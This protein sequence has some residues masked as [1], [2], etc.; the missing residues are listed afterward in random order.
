MKWPGGMTKYVDKNQCNIGCVCL[1]VVW[2][3]TVNA[4]RLPHSLHILLFEAG[5][6]TDWLCCLSNELWGSTCL[7]LP[8]IGITDS[9]HSACFYMNSGEPVS[10]HSKC[11]MDRNNLPSSSLSITRRIVD[12]CALTIIPYRIFLANF[13]FSLNITECI[14]P[15]S[16]HNEDSVSFISKFKFMLPYDSLLYNHPA[17]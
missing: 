10:L 8:S 16:G 5:S 4:K 6:L 2:K 9:C 14:R 7:G 15:M 12:R 13:I 1:C 17:P 3:S 11:L